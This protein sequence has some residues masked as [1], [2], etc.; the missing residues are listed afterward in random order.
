MIAPPCALRRAIGNLLQNAL[1]YAPEGGIEL[2]PVDERRGPAE[3][4]MLGPEVAVPV[5][6]PAAR[7]TFG[8][9]R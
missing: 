9:E 8:E 5:D 6:D 1:R 3:R 4:D 2:E 7:N